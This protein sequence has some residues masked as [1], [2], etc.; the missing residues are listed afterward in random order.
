MR[1]RI[2]VVEDET[3]IRNLIVLHLKRE[4]FDVDEVEDGEKARQLISKNKYDLFIFDCGGRPIGH[5]Q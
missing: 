2:L 4:G 3:E 1:K 5:P